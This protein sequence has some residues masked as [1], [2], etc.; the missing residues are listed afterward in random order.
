MQIFNRVISQTHIIKVT[1][2]KYSLLVQ[3]L[4]FSHI[5]SSSI[6]F[7]LLCLFNKLKNSLNCFCDFLAISKITKCQYNI[8]TLIDNIIISFY[9]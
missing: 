7:Q 6:Y 2:T 3:L 8:L 9:N 5:Y 1:I 4:N